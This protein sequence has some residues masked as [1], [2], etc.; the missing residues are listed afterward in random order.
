M[1]VNSCKMSNTIHKIR[2]MLNLPQ[3]RKFYAEAK[4]DDGRMIVTE[5]DE[6]S[7]GAELFVM[8]DEGTTEELQ[9]GQ[10]TLED[11]T[12]IKVEEGRLAA[13][14]DEEMEDHGDKEEMGDEKEEMGM[15]DKLKEVGL[16]DDMADKVI[17]IVEEM[18][19]GKKE[20]MSEEAVEEVAEEVVAE[21]EAAEDVEYVTKEDF[22]AL[23]AQV[24][25][26]FKALLSRV[27][28]VEDEPADT[29]VKVSPAPTELKSHKAA[30]TFANAQEKALFDIINFN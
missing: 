8:T 5:S 26:G 3:L 1:G 14:G 9:A 12:I 28:K 2:E 24:S 15:K 16:E 20:E 11:G 27:E 18:G 30:P 4:L 17:K 10:Y 22:Q 6:M 19:Y 29:G 21:E 13:M 7:M 25:E 23:A